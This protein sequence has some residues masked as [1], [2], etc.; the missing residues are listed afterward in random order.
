[1]EKKVL[2]GIGVTSRMTLGRAYVLRDPAA[3]EVQ[4]DESVEAALK[5]LHAAVEESIHQTQALIERSQGEQTDILISHMEF[6]RDPAFNDGADCAVRA[7]ETPENVILRT[8]QE[9]STVFSQ[10][11]DAY[12]RERAADINDVGQRI[13]R[14]LMQIESDDLSALPQNTVLVAK[15]LVPSQTVQLGGGGVCGFVTEL[16]GRTSHTAIIANAMQMPAV[17]GCAGCLDVIKT[18]DTLIVDAAGGKVVLH[19][20]EQEKSACLHRLQAQAEQEQTRK[21]LHGRKL[22]APD[23]REIHVEANIGSLADA[24]I[25][26]QNGAD[27]VGLF[28]TEF[29]FLSGEHMP[30][31]DTQFAAYAEIAKRFGARTVTIRTLDIGGDKALPYLPQMHE[32]NPFLGVRAIRLCRQ[33][34]ELLQ[35]QL[36]AIL[37]ASAFGRLRIMF[38]MI[39][40][41]EE[42]DW[43][44]ALLCR[45]M[46]EL[47]EQQVPFDERI[48]VGMM[49]ETP[50]AAVC[51]EEFARQADFFSI[52]T[53]DLTQ[54]TLAVDRGNDRLAHLYDPQHPAVLKLIRHTIAAAHRNGIPCCLCGE[55]ASAPA[56]TAMLLEAGLDT[57]SV[58]MAMVSET[59][60]RLLSLGCKDAEEH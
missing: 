53:N 1:M 15:E 58:G 3:N 37:R 18:G 19:P 25:A 5:R 7:G 26:L 39:A 47:R 43:A 45:C 35:T 40:A 44:K 21:R 13:L 30:D 46:Q 59:K 28:R 9:L 52:G 56:A 12:L 38:P 29:L 41:T 11:D 14:N 55:L 42:W 17:V 48:P 23:G 31:E 57:F 51:A 33:Q 49:I 24:E 10:L 8:V 27:G 34:P 16:G 60:E 50:A 6:L 32:D 2:T 20:T 4:V 54:Y 22:Y 36:R